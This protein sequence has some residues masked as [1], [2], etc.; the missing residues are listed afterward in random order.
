MN[1]RILIID[2]D[3]VDQK[4][5]KK[6]LEKAGFDIIFTADSG[7]KGLEVARREKPDLVIVDPLLP[8]MDGHETCRQIKQLGP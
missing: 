1:K 4:M 6:S 7:E 2:D 5:M 3:H 8:G